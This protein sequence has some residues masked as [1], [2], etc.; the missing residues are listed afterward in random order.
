M[1]VVNMIGNPPLFC[2]L[3]PSK[4]DSPSHSSR[5]RMGRFAVR[6]DKLEVL[7]I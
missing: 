5:S 4:G 3:N 1:N 2:S 6:L 7:Q